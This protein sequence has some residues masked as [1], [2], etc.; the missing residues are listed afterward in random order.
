MSPG[1]IWG[2][3]RRRKGWQ[4]NWQG[5]CLSCLVLP[6]CASLERWER[7]EEGMGN[8][9]WGGIGLGR[10]KGEMGQSRDTCLE[11][12]RQSKHN[13]NKRRLR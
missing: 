8:A 7:Q 11:G 9:R 1:Q 6:A 3:R 10:E 12:T 13:L 5:A 4:R 2:L